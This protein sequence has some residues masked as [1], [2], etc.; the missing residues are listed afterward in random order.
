MNIASSKPFMARFLLENSPYGLATLNSLNLL[1]SKNSQNS[2]N[3][4]NPS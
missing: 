2:F 1:I 3:A 4:L